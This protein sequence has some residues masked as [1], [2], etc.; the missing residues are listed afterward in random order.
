MAKAGKKLTKLLTQETAI[1]LP[2]SLQRTDN[3][4]P[5]NILR[6]IDKHLN[7]Q[8]GQYNFILIQAFILFKNTN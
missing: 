3:S 2:H 1:T 5:N 7:P 4:G 6:K 8:T